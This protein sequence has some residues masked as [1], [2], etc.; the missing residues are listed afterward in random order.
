MGKRKPHCY[1]ILITPCFLHALIMQRRKER[2]RSGATL[3]SEQV[4]L[5]FIFFKSINLCKALF[6]Y[7]SFH[8]CS[9]GAALQYKIYISHSF[10]HFLIYK[11]SIVV[12]NKRPLQNFVFVLSRLQLFLLQ[13]CPQS[14]CFRSMLNVSFSVLSSKSLLFKIPLSTLLPT[15]LALFFYHNTS[16][17]VFKYVMFSMFLFTK[18]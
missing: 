2:K 13:K 11:I 17:S 5:G 9:E 1:T 16:L 14:A 8:S 15:F 3:Q 12:L 6:I 4:S 10:H 18:V 7:E